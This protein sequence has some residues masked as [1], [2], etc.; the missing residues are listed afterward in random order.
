MVHA[1]PVLPFLKSADPSLEIH[2]LVEGPFAPLLEDHP[3]IHKVLRINTRTWRREGVTRICREALRTFRELHA[4]NYEIALD[5]QGNSKSG[6]FTLFSGAPLRYGFDRTACREWPN[7]LATTKRVSLG[8]SE[9]HISDRSLAVAAAAFPEG[10]ERPLAGPLPVD[11]VLLKSV[12][13]RLLKKG[14]IDHPVIVLHH[15]TTWET[16][17]WPQENWAD[18][19][20]ELCGSLNLRPVLTWGDDNELEVV[21]MIQRA[22]EGTAL[23]WPRGSLKELAALLKMA[24]IVVGTDTGPLHMAAAVGTPTVS[25]YRVTDS[26]RNGPRGDKHILLQVPL[27]CSP[28]LLK[29]CERDVECSHSIDVQDVLGAIETLIK[30][31][32]NFKPG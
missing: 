4:E 11:P 2:W 3:F 1:L 21:K 30:R 10:N 20:V 6:L 31:I 5:L 17:R 15:G 32:D 12:K 26:N 18:L 14:L 29:E 13:N 23:I 27:D 8:E 25:L 24:D 16:K 9:Y 22:T 7:L 28:C 19:T